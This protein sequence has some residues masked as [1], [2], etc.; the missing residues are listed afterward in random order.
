M[1]SHK[2]YWFYGSRRDINEIKNLRKLIFSSSKVLEVGAHIGYLTQLF[3][4]LLSP[5]GQIIVVEPSPINRKFLTRNIKKTTL[6]LPI[7][8]SNKIGNSKFFIDSYGGFTNS[9]KENFTFF[10]NI[11]L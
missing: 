6:I 1:W 4:N 7:A 2:G 11:E 3:E 9:L 8:L 10:K 5:N